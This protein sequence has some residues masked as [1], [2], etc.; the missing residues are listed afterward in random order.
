[1]LINLSLSEKEA[2][3]LSSLFAGIGEGDSVVLEILTDKDSG[4]GK[5]NNGQTPTFACTINC[6]GSNNGEDEQNNIHPDMKTYD[7][8]FKQNGNRT[9]KIWFTCE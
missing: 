8:L 9:E 2:L 5:I 6:T 3:W 4:P 7:N 1:M